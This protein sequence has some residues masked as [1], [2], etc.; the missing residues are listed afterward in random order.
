MVEI[1]THL[2]K[3]IGI[4]LKSKG[5]VF[6]SRRISAAAAD[7]SPDVEKFRALFKPTNRPTSFPELCIA[8][9]D[10]RC[11]LFLFENR[12]AVNKSSRFLEVSFTGYIK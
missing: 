4:E 1:E 3:A 5:R 7:S 2:S 8:T 9:V 12:I 11:F 6:I 10:V